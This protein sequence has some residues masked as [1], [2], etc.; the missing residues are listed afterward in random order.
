L[1]ALIVAGTPVQIQ[2]AGKW[3]EDNSIP[4]HFCNAFS[5]S[6]IKNEFI[7]TF[8]CAIPPVID[9]GMKPEDLAKLTVNVKPLVRIGMTPDRVIELIGLLQSQLKNYSQT[10]QS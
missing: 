3:L 5:V 2:I 10:I 4:I 9:Q 6:P 1:E 7:L 8:A